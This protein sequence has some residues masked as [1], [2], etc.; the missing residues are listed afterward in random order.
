LEIIKKCG[1]LI[2]LELPEKTAELIAGQIAH[3]Q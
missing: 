1:H 2:T 3:A